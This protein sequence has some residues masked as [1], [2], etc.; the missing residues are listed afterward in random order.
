MTLLGRLRL[1]GD[2]AGLRIGLLG[3][4]LGGVG[5]HGHRTLF[6]TTASSLPFLVIF[7]HPTYR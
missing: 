7:A 2:I 3:R 1:V 6:L 5:A 4:I